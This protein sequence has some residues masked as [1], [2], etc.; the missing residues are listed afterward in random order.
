MFTAVYQFTTKVL[1][2]SIGI[3]TLLG[4]AV[5]L[6]QGYCKLNYFP[7]STDFNLVKLYFNQN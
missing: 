7:V 4:F 6:Q 5:V 1:Q 3:T 2:F